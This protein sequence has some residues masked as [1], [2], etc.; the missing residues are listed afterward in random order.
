MQSFPVTIRLLKNNH[1]DEYI[2]YVS[3]VRPKIIELADKQRRKE[4]LENFANEATYKGGTRY[5]LKRKNV[6]ERVLEKKFERLQKHL[7]GDI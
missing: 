6:K 1:F 3:E 4:E 2:K 5:P 7:K